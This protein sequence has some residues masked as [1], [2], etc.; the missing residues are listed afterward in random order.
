MAKT[1]LHSKRSV[2]F[3]FTAAVTVLGAAPSALADGN[4]WFSPDQLGPGRSEYSQKCSV[5]HGAQL[6]GG[7]APA[8]KGQIFIKQ[9][10]G[11]SLKDFYSYVRDQMPLGQARSL[12]PQEYADVVAYMLAQSGLPSGNQ[13]LTATRR[14][15][16]YLSSRQR[17]PVRRRPHRHHRLKSANSTVRSSSRP[18][19]GLPRRNSTRPTPIRKVG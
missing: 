15:S 16:R 18:L 1:H 3:A 5:C 19:T 10:S 11:K 6:Q 4:G 9:W 8:L 13:K 14:C 12:D 17:R 2:G 7:G